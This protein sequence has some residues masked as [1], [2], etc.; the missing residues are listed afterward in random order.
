MKISKAIGKIKE[1][2]TKMAEEDKPLIYKI[3]LLGDMSVG[4]THLLTRY[5]KDQIPRYPQPT[6]GIEFASKVIT[7]PNGKEATVTI[8]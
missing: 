7:L 1:K 8:K 5:L 2:G 4:K 3:I 6:I